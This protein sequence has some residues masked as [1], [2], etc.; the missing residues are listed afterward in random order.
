VPPE[1]R[2]APLLLFL[3]LLACLGLRAEAAG[4]PKLIFRKTIPA[5]ADEGA[6]PY[7]VKQGEYIYS[8]MRSLKVAPS[9]MPLVMER[10]KEL[11]PQ[12]ENFNEV[13]P[14]QTLYL[15]PSVLRAKKK[16]KPRVPES[17][18]QVPTTEYTVKPGDH[19][20]DLLRR[21]AGLPE[22]LIFNEYLTLFR[23]LNPQVENINSLEVGQTVAIPLKPGEEPAASRVPPREKATAPDH[24]QASPTEGKG[25]QPQTTEAAPAETPNRDLVLAM[26][27]R[28][29]FHRSGGNE[30]LYP[31]ER[32]GWVQI[33]LK[34]TPLLEAPWEE[35]L[36]LVPGGHSQDTELLKQ[37]DLTLCRIR[38]DWEPADVFQE[39]ERASQRRF[40][41]WGPDQDLILN[42][43]RLV[44]EIQARYQCIIQNGTGKEH[45][46]FLPTRRDALSHLPLLCGFLAGKDIRLHRYRPK[47]SPPVISAPEPPEAQGLFVPK[48]GFHGLWKRFA[49][50]L[51]QDRLPSPPVD[52]SSQ[53]LLPYLKAKGLVGSSTLRLKWAANPHF[54][55]RISLQAASL[56]L[57]EASYLLSREVQDPYLVALLNAQGYACYALE[58]EP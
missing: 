35:A 36:L 27:S 4:T 12:I 15:P 44:I 14:G 20:V 5:T 55:C 50:E 10:I 28:A 49:R 16:Q 25:R 34:E 48:I 52:T 56:D 38:A 58:P 41:F 31:L 54:E 18:S 53:A 46:V 33:D 1:G 32:G 7:T 57:K 23:E 26:L 9:K 37:T 6:T 30:I 21:I 43:P 13:Y 19:L 47:A 2:I 45:H 39:L 17:L 51:P 11:N 40:T 22:S 29:G 8:I 24:T 42:F 3:L